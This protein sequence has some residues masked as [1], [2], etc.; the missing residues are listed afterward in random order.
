M[1]KAAPRHLAVLFLIVACVIGAFGK[2]TPA[3]VLT[4]PE[5]GTQLVSFELGK[6][7]RFG[8]HSGQN[9]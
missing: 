9:D 8:W 3:Q 4:W 7:E 5:S 2:D 6:F 1:V